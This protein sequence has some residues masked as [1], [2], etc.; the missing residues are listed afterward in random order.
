MNF[1]AAERLGV[2]PFSRIAV[3]DDTP[4][5][6]VAGLNAGA[7]TVAVTK[8][9]NALGLSEAEIANLPAGELAARLKAIEEKFREIGA[10][11]VIESVADLPKII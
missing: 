2:Y 11:Y 9:G 10:D 7:V 4:V 6:I 5:G 1:K 3:V 8:T